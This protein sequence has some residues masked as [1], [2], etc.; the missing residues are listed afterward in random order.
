M[1]NHTKNAF[2]LSKIPSFDIGIS[3]AGYTVVE[4]WNYT[5]A[6]M[7]TWLLYWNRDNGAELHLNGSIRQMD[8]STLFLIPPYTT[9]STRSRNSFSHFYLHFDAPPPFDRVKREILSFSASDAEKYLAAII[10]D[11]NEMMRAAVFRALIYGYLMQIPKN[12][13]LS[14]EESA[15][16][17]RIR[18]ALD[19]MSR[20]FSS[21]PGNSTLCRRVGMSL[22]NFYHLFQKETGTTPG[23]YLL[24]QRMESARR[25]L[26][27]T[28]MSI[29]EIAA[30]NGYADRYHFSKAFKRFYSSAPGNYR[31]TF[32]KHFT[33]P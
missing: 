28:D 11:E 18:R 22:N 30:A 32:Q 29:D 4:Q 24:N 27:S 33:I 17:P 19:I 1:S 5:N 20:D 12:V 3:C 31:K 6:N 2:H 16:D 8:P 25:Q 23:H 14:S 10:E 13:F 9:F 21:I 26:I 7:G 15:L